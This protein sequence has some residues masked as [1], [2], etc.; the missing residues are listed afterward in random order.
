VRRKNRVEPVTL[1]QARRLRRDVTPAES[2]L[3]KRLRN[4]QMLGLKFCRQFAVGPFVT[5]FCCPARK[6]VVEIDGG[7]HAETADK[8]AA[9]TEFLGREGYRVVRFTN[10]D[11]HRNIAAV[12]ESIA[13]ECGA[14]D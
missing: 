9:R 2:T 4:R 14:L 1:A 12:L 6:L 8:D 3:W 7:S 5:D 10:G 11:V 13:R